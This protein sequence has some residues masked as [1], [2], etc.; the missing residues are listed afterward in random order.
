MELKT[1]TEALRGHPFLE[2]MKP[3]HVQKM[4]EV[5]ME[6]QFNRDQVIFREGDESSLFY[7]LL[8]GK[9]ALEVTAPGRIVRVQT[10][11]EGDELGW[12]SL[13]GRHGKTFQAR[14]I[15]PVRAIAFDGT[16]LRHACEMDPAFGYQLMQ[17]VL[18]VV[19]ERL[20]AT[21]LQLIDVF[22]PAGSKL[23]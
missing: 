14:S 2:G 6:V 7:L 15:E 21:R 4:A 11:G 16:R 1:L 20:Q 23:A 18:R 8:T 12:S 13:I 10:L 9:V 3:N 19:A 22:A 17:R 5:A